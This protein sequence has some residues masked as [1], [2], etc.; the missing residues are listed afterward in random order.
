M[1]LAET[2]RLLARLYTNGV[3]R[4]RFF[5][6]PLKVGEELGL[7]PDDAHEMARLSARD[8]N[9]FASSLRNKRLREVCE[10][11]PLTHRVLGSR[12]AGLFRQHSDI[13]TPRGVKKHRDDAIAFATHL[14]KIAS[15]DGSIPGWVAELI[16]YEKAWLKAADPGCRIIIRWFRY[17][18]G[19]LVRRGALGDDPSVPLKQPSLALWF[20]LSRRGRLRHRVLT[21]PSLSR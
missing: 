7:N 16:R 18:V 17:A 3:L 1:G 10:L 12:I 9:L 15:Q 13:Y 4:E 19:D 14:E 11:L 20:R 5:A 2:Q 6:D 21:L 8:V